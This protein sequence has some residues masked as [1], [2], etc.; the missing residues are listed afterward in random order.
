M[1]AEQDDPLDEAF[2]VKTSSGGFRFVK[3]S[4]LERLRE[5]PFIEELKAKPNMRLTAVRNRMGAA[6]A[7]PPVPKTPESIRLDEVLRLAD[8]RAQQLGYLAQ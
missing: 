6:A 4:K 2:G 5:A 7:P 3:R 1:D 8:L